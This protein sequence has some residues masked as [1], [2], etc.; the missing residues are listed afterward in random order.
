MATHLASLGADVVIA[1]RREHVVKD[2]AA[3]ISSETGARVEGISLDVRDAAAVRSSIRSTIA[4][5]DGDDESRGAAALFPGRTP[6]LVIN[7]AAG[8]F[9][10]PTERLS[11]NAFQAIM[12][13]VL[14]GSFNVTLE[15]AK[16]LMEQQKRGTFLY[17]TTIYAETG[18]A[19]V[20]PSACAKAGVEALI[21]SLA[22]EW[23]SKGMRFVG[24]APGPIPTEGAFSRLDPEGKFEKGLARRNPTGRLGTKEELANLVTFL[25]SDYASW[26]NGE[27]VAVDGGEKRALAGE[28]NIVGDMVSE[29]EWDQIEAAVRAAN[30]KSKGKK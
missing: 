26:I 23:G 3:A 4:G 5:M 18:S 10:S 6:D 30:A 14:V 24:V 1:G 22:A 27:I 28:F 9:I 7:N 13:T 19:Y 8:N 15:C 21:K 2:T 25:M 16:A 11:T 20:V 17:T 12:N 29:K